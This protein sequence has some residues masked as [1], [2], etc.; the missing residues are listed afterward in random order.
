MFGLAEALAHLERALRLWDGVADAAELVKVDLAELCS[1]AAELAS[2][3]GAAPHAVELVQRAIELVGDGDR[4]RAALLY[5]RLGRYLFESGGGDTFLAALERA[6]E[7]VPAHPPSAERARA[8]AALAAGL[9]LT[10]RH[11]ESLAICEQALELA[12]AVGA[13]SAELRALRCSAAISPISA[14]PRRASR[15]RGRPCSSPRSVEIPWRWTERTSRS[16]TC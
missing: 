6:V 4:L 8:L 14:A 2:Q 7:L 5:E 13:R 1:W 3:T 12:R 16:P 15:G 10:W 11:E 9:Q